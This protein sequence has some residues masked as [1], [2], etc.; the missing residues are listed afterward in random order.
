MTGGITDAVLPLWAALLAF[1]A[2]AAAAYGAILLLR[3]LLL[4]FALAHANARSSHTQPT[5]QGGGLAVV[6]ALLAIVVTGFAVL[7]PRGGIA[8]LQVAA[9]IAATLA[10]AL[11]GAADDIRGLA[12]A[13][14]LAVHVIA[15]AAV[16]YALPDDV[17]LAPMLPVWGDRVLMLLAALW[18][19]NLVNFMD[20]I[21]WM[22]V[23]EV[24]PV[25]AGLAL[26]GA[27]GALPPLATLT[28]IALAG[29][30]L[31]FAPFNRPVARLF[32]GDA[33]SVPVGL[34]LAWLLLLLA[35]Q[36]HAAA[37]VLLPLY[38]LADA[39]ITL[40][41]RLARGEK[42]WQAHRTHFYQRATDHG[43]T[44]RDIVGHVFAV[45]LGLVILAIATMFYPS[46]P[47]TIAALA[48]GASL[49]GWLLLRFSSRASH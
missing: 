35:A 21:D 14:K 22:T 45:N 9:V 27:L 6:G 48:L 44:V 46:M 47:V 26:A 23:A 11:T 33:G 20:G 40:G 41:R 7:G 1:A 32:L 3:P 24:V 13:P 5:P 16:V 37:A 38:Y 43:W 12:P 4:R 31:G 8:S 42:I 2:A 25:A 17:R 30:M 39:T 49:V 29:A 19:I 28:A 36:G 18:F 10:L 15:V 34:I